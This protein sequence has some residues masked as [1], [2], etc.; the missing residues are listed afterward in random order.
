MIKAREIV[1]ENPELLSEVQNLKETLSAHSK[2][3]EQSTEKL[4]RLEA[5]NLVLRDENH[6]LHTTSSKGRRFQTQVRPMKPLDTPINGEEGARRPQPQD[7]EKETEGNAV[8]KTRTRVLEDSDS[9]MEDE[10]ETTKAAKTSEPVMTAFG[11]N[12]L[13]SNF[14]RP[15]AGHRPPDSCKEG[16]WFPPLLPTLPPGKQKVFYLRGFFHI[17]EY[18]RI[19]Q[20]T[21]TTI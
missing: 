1:T 13:V 20:P 2:Q 15:R 18:G 9:E 12:T 11:K 17:S 7:G 8:N 19:L 4:I 14:S 21:S 3:L 6:A 10:E 16:P 5:E